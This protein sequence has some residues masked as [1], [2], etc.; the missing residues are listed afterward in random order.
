VSIGV[1]FHIGN[2]SS[3]AIEA[4]GRL[5]KKSSLLSTLLCCRFA[6]FAYCFFAATFF[7]SKLLCVMKFFAIFFKKKIF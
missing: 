3:I 4:A 2:K 7:Y 6:C 5:Q 1:Y